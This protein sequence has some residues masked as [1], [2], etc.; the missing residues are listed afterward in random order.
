MLFR[1]W[2]NAAGRVARSR[3]GEEGVVGGGKGRAQTRSKAPLSPRHLPT[4][5]G[6]NSCSGRFA[7]RGVHSVEFSHYEEMPREF[8]QKVIEESKKAK[9]Q[10]E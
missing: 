1:L 2:R 9:Q 7:R 4:R 5:A 3:D 8:E 6:L 10:Q